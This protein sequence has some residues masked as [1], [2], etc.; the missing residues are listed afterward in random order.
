[1]RHSGELGEEYGWKSWVIPLWTTHNSVEQIIKM[2]ECVKALM[3][4]KVVCRFPTLEL[5]YALVHPEYVA[6]FDM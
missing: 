6:V 1:M 4:V 5:S 3:T 2:V